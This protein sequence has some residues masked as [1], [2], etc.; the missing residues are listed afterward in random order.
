MFIGL[1]PASAEFAPSEFFKNNCAACHGLD[2]R[3]QT[4]AAK[5]LKV[6]D[7]TANTAPEAELRKRI[8]NGV[9]D[10]AGTPRM[11]AF[12]DALNPEQIAGMA[13]YVL[14]LRPKK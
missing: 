7:L 5:M 11:P 2:G 8:E 4:P 13:G 6:K 3:A 9:K 1:A 10:K 12:K 14:S